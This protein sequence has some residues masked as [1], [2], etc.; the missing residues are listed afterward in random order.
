MNFS[1]T[2]IWYS[3]YADKFRFGALGSLSFILLW[4][5]WVVVDMNDDDDFVPAM[6]REQKNHKFKMMMDLILS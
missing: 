2:D 5:M 6:I 1:L 3:K 4:G